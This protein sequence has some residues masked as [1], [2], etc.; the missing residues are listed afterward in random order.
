MVS[1]VHGERPGLVRCDDGRA[2]QVLNDV[3]LLDQH[4]ALLK[5]VETYCNVMLW[6]FSRHE[7]S[8]S[9]ALI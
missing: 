3:S 2:A 5:R 6:D 1:L 8:G 9:T 4:V 7:G